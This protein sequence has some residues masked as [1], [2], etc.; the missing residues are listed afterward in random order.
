[1]AKT[2]RGNVTLGRCKQCSCLPLDFRTCLGIKQP[3]DFFVSM[4]GRKG[5]PGRRFQ[6]GKG[7]S[8]GSEST[9]VERTEG[10]LDLKVW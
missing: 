10:L 9:V 5:L 1:M 2:N 4:A 8:A 7:A 3:I 6:R